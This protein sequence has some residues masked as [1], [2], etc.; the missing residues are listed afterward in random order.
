MERNQAKLVLLEFFYSLY[1]YWQGV[2]DRKGPSVVIFHLFPCYSLGKSIAASLQSPRGYRELPK[3]VTRQEGIAHGCDIG[4]LCLTHGIL[5]DPGVDVPAQF[6]LQGCISY[7]NPQQEFC[8]TIHCICSGQRFI[9]ERVWHFQN[10]EDKSLIQFFSFGHSTC[11]LRQ[12][13]KRK[14]LL[15]LLLNLQPLGEMKQVI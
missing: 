6:Q 8:N 10:F 12:D 7:I 9:C 4:V 15:C 14:W 3:A 5:R 1:S 2:R 13:P 11:S